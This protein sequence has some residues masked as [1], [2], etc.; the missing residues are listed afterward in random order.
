MDDATATLL[1]AED[2]PVIRLFLAD[3]LIADGYELIVTECFEEAL[4]ALERERPDL[5]VF[6]VHLPDGSGLDL[7][8][9]VRGADGVA[10]RLDPT[11]PVVMLSG[12]AAELDRLRGLERGA[13]DYVAKPFSYAELRL[14]IAAVLRRARSSG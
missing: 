7:L 10:S 2:D 13:D 6:D 5:A 4:E 3:N 8:R 11:L 1:L 14:R 9:R 12:A